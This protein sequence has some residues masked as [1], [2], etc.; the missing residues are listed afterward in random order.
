MTTTSPTTPAHRN[1]DAQASA[2]KVRI[3]VDALLDRAIGMAHADAAA[4]I[5]MAA[6]ASLTNE[7]LATQLQAVLSE[8]ARLRTWVAL[9]DGDAEAVAEGREQVSS[10]V[11]AAEVAGPEPKP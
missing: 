11:P 9:H 10:A 4:H 3:D 1:A 6:S 7:G 2:P 5:K 8:N